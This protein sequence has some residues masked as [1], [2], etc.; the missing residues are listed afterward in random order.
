MRENRRGFIAATTCPSTPRDNAP[1]SRACRVRVSENGGL[2]DGPRNLPRRNARR[3]TTMH[4]PTKRGDLAV[5]G[6]NAPPAGRR[7]GLSRVSPL[8]AEA[9]RGAQRLRIP[10]RDL[11]MQGAASNFKEQPHAKGLPQDSEEQPHAKGSP[12]NLEEQP[13]AKGLPQDSE[14]QPHAKGLPQDS[15]EQP[16]AKELP[17]DSEEQPHAKELRGAAGSVGCARRTGTER[18]RHAQL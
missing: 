10:G 15:E 16:H 8:P 12:R 4:A 3:N 9:Q 17:Q 13:H 18:I 1:I 5:A 14:E 2:W 6:W 11:P 7:R